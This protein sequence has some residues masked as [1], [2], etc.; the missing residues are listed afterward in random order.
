MPVRPPLVRHLPHR[1]PSR[2]AGSLLALAVLALG[3]G[4]SGGSPEE[5]QEPA[6][7]AST[8]SGGAAASPSDG[9]PAAFPRRTVPIVD[10]EVVSADADRGGET[11]TVL[12][13]VEDATRSEAVAD[14]VGRLERRGW[15]AT[16]E[17]GDQDPPAPQVLTRGE[18]RVVLVNQVQ[19]DLTALTY[20]VRTAP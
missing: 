18:A 5:D 1:P 3:T 4:C 17:P 2:R 16:G 9:L 20:S 8:A 12:V 6:P 19:R 14:A 15:T 10:G 13:Y 11:F 7:P